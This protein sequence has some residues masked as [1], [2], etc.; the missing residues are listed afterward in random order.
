M[1]PCIGHVLKLAVQDVFKVAFKSDTLT[2]SEPVSYDTDDVEYD[3]I[4]RLR[5]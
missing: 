4:T 2:Q 5:R 1:I 3:V